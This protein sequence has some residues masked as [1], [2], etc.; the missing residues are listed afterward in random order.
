MSEGIAKNFVLPKF[1]ASG[2]EMLREVI[3]NSTTT[4]YKFYLN[5]LK[6]TKGQSISVSVMLKAGMKVTEDCSFSTMNPQ[7]HKKGEVQ[8]YDNCGRARS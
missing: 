3:E 8:R 2:P 5:G 4:R 1:N 7:Y 6:V